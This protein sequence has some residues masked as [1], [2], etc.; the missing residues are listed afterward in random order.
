MALENFH[1]PSRPVYLLHSIKNVYMNMLA[2][3]D[4][5]LLSYSYWWRQDKGPTMA[6][7]PLAVILK[8]AQ[9]EA[10]C[11]NIFIFLVG[12]FLIHVV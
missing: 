8:E 7:T 2:R 10:Q 3:S 11:C 6:N 12:A 5:I 1:P 4:V 9:G